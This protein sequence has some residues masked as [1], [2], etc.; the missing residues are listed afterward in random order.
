MENK[1]GLNRVA[2][3]TASGKLAV[4]LI[5]G[6]TLST[7]YGSLSSPKTFFSEWWFTTLVALLVL[8]T[9]GCTLRQWRTAV[10]R[11]QRLRSNVLVTKSVQTVFTTSKPETVLVRAAELLRSQRYS[12]MLQS[13]RIYAYKNAVGFF[14]SPLFH[15]A[16]VGLALSA[17]LGVITGTWGRF[18]VSEQDVF[19]EAAENYVIFEKR[20]LAPNNPQRFSLK[21]DKVTVEADEDGKILRFSAAVT[22]FDQQG[23]ELTHVI[24]RR[25]PLKINGVT[26]YQHRFG[27]APIFSLVQGDRSQVNFIVVLETFGGLGGEQEFSGELVIPGTSKTSFMQFHPE[28]TEVNVNIGEE[29]KAMSTLLAPGEWMEIPNDEG[30]LLF[31][32][33]R[34]WASF[35]AVGDSWRTLTFTMFWVAIFGLV[36]MYLFNPKAIQVTFLLENGVGIVATSSRF[37]I[38]FEAEVHHYIDQLK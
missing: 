18:G 16:L 21:L 20:L 27:Y 11:Y 15:T 38:L 23:G 25:S 13:E 26:L 35:T 34:H 8:N 14:G 28:Q 24:D 29:A 7:V 22:V 9:W 36:M 30:R 6:L 10:R 19:T 4:V 37:K 3:I 2:Q 1:Q 17:T 12:I 32:D 31:V 33:W 5:A